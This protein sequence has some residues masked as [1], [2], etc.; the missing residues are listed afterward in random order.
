MFVLIPGGRLYHGPRILS[1][2]L[3]LLLT[4]STHQEEALKVRSRHS[5][6][7]QS[8]CVKTLGQG[9]D[10]SLSGCNIFPAVIKYNC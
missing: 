4:H 3:L 7:L 1:T 9:P 8:L 5:K 2:L 6:P 10:G